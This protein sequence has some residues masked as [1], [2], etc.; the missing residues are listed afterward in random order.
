MLINDIAV[1][2]AVHADRL[3]RD[4]AAV[5]VACFRRD[6]GSSIRRSIGRSMVRLGARLAAERALELARS[7]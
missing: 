7:G 5:E 3:S 1:I 6:S 4:V 2:R